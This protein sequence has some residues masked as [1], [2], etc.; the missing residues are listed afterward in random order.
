MNHNIVDV[1][2][3]LIISDLQ[4][5]TA[6]NELICNEDHFVKIT[7]EVPK[8]ENFGDFS[9]NVAMVLS[10]TNRCSPMQIGKKIVDKLQQHTEIFEKVEIVKPG[11]I[12]LF[13]Q[14]DFIL[15][16]FGDV[17]ELGE[18]FSEHDIWQNETVNLEF[19]SANPT[20]PMHIGHVRGAII[21]DV[22]ANLLQKIGAK[23]TREYYINDAGGQILALLKSVWL[24][25]QELQGIE[26]EIPADCYPGEYIIN[27]ATE[28]YNLKFENFEQFCVT[29]REFVLEEIMQMIKSDL[30]LL[31]V[32]HDSFVSEQGIQDRNLIQDA[33]VI[34]QKK[35]FLYYGILEKPKGKSDEDWEEREQL[36]FKSSK[37]GDEVDR[38]LQKSDE[39]WTYFAGDLAYHFDKCQRDF[40]KIFIILGCDHIGY[41]KRIKAV[42][43]AFSDGKKS[44]STIF[45]DI[46]NFFEKGEKIKMSKRAGKFLTAR[47]VAEKVGVDL[48]RFMMI[49][50]SSEQV[51]NFDF[52]EVVRQSK[53]NPIFYIQYAHARC[54]SILRNFSAEYIHN[55][56]AKKSEFL[57]LL[58][59]NEEKKL[60]KKILLWPEQV[61]R[62]ALCAEPH[63]ICTF[64]LELVTIF[65][66]LWSLGRDDPK[67]R[68]I[69]ENNANLTNARLLLTK[70]TQIVIQDALKILNIEAMDSM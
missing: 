3:K 35:D 26:I 68:F 48:T 69:L 4:K 11:F 16:K 52:E 10:R 40:S 9:T 31:R 63:Q 24:R 20:G 19:V 8:N 41:E 66:S 51:I 34:L 15:K 39:S 28:I 67:R 17:F 59:E 13:L 43:N 47:D 57:H 27:I 53:E 61:K 33:I 42:V 30:T 44:L 7:V 22:L 23:V 2:T 37:F 46:V 12:N 36:L 5:L 49:S 6:A 50:K 56:V 38:A 58:Q 45:Y 54:C 70:A 62:I 65:H 29:Q 1:L 18:N 14:N 64:L 60:I 55:I 21:G 32:H 25:M